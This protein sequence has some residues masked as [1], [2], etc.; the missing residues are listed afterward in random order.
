MMI[1]SIISDI[2]R[3]KAIEIFREDLRKHIEQI[4][5]DQEEKIESSI[6]IQELK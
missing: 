6:P 4:K 5:K 1:A 2:Q 3:Q